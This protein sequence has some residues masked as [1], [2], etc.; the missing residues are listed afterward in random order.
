[1]DTLS[2]PSWH[3]HESLTCREEAQHAPGPGQTPSL[4]GQKRSGCSHRMEAAVAYQP[5]GSRGT[6]RPGLMKQQQLSAPPPGRYK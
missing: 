4:V 1:M 6:T 3:L 2:Y 5:W